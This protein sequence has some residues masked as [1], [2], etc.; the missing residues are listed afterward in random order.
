MDTYQ[1]VIIKN[2]WTS[3]GAIYNHKSKESTQRKAIITFVDNTGK[4]NNQYTLAEKNRWHEIRLNGIATLD[5]YLS[6]KI[7]HRKGDV[8]HTKMKL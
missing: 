5:K 7:Q 1:H 4:Y 2:N 3:K 6:R 8:L